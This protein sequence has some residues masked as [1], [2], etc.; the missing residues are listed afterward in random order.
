MSILK[1]KYRIRTNKVLDIN[2]DEF[3]TYYFTGNIKKFHE[4]QIFFRKNT[5]V[6]SIIIFHVHRKA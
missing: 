2:V 4:S 1:H 6:L 5:N 3:G